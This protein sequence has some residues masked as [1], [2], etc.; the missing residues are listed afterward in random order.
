M[1]VETTRETMNAYLL[2]VLDQGAYARYLAPDVILTIAGTG[3]QAKG[4]E[5]VATLIALV[6][7]GAS[8]GAHELRQLVCEAGRAAVEAE[9]AH[10]QEQVPYAAMYRLADDQI[11]EIRL[12]GPVID[13]MTQT[14]DEDQSNRRVDMR[15]RSEA[16][17][18]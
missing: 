6:G 5:S 2:A 14:M 7:M 18:E 15:R 9:Y 8:G 4:R 12:Y 17:V 16:D 13:L 11:R 1:S 3:Q 10:G